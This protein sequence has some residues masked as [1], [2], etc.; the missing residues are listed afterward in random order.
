[1]STHNI[2][3]SEEIR[4]KNKKKQ[5]LIGKKTQKNVPL[6]SGPMGFPRMMG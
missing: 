3:F 1:M 2:C 4:K 5:F 6:I